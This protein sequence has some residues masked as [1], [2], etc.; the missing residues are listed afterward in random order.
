[1]ASPNPALSISGCRFALSAPQSRLWF[2]AS[3][4]PDDPSYHVPLAIHLK[5]ALNRRALEATLRAI[6]EYHESLRTAFLSEDG[7]PYQFI[8][9]T[10]DWSLTYEDCPGIDAAQARMET[11]ARVPFALH[12]APLMRAALLRVAPQE[13]ILYVNFHHLICDG[14]SLGVL[15]EHLTAGYQRALEGLPIELSGGA[16]QYADYSEWQ[17]QWLDDSRLR[18]AREY[19]KARLASAGRSAAPSE[20]HNPNVASWEGGVV[21]D[22][23]S[24]TLVRAVQE[25]AESRGATWFMAGLAAFQ[26]LLHRYTGDT[27]IVTGTPVAN[28]PMAEFE[29]V[30]GFFVN[31]LPLRS[32]IDPSQTFHELLESV[33]QGCVGAFEHQILPFEQMLDLVDRSRESLRTPLFPTFFVLQNAPLGRIQWPGL[34][35]ATVPVHNGSAKVDFTLTAEPDDRGMS[36]TLEFAAARFSA[37]GARRML[38]RY[39]SALAA[40][41]ANPECRVRHWPMLTANEREEII[42][43]GR[44]RCVC[45]SRSIHG[46]F[47]EVAARRG[48][49]AAVASTEERLSYVEL[50]RRAN[51]LEIG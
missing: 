43:S 20:F 38:D 25:L 6:I 4:R 51:G 29:S 42:V 39:K 17:T 35:V 12:R 34:E 49:A 18:P 37:A 9:S 16:L 10:A 33:K 40:V 24:L 27:D 14:W 8:Q 48:E 11:D 22:R 26:G 19:W 36:L 5:G 44:P 13:H 31:S 21:R 15:V 30:V 23:L 47:E 32:L 45:A 7:V 1:M 2:L 28:R 41:V 46:W 3:V 50:N